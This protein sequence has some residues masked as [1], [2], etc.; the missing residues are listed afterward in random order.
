MLKSAWPLVNWNRLLFIQIQILIPNWK[1]MFDI[2]WETTNGNIIFDKLPT[3][4]SME[5]ENSIE[6]LEY[7][8][9]Y[10]LWHS[11]LTWSRIE[12]QRLAAN[13]AYEALWLRATSFQFLAANW[14][15]DHS[16]F[17]TVIN[18]GYSEYPSSKFADYRMKPNCT[19]DSQYVIWW[20]Q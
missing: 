15:W 17:H 12:S 9:R 2:V 14:A 18:L 13:S 20:Q 8:N 10:N 5:L 1:E 11:L 3:K 6:V 16:P 4:S 19:W 7:G